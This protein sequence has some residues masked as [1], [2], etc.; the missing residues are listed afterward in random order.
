MTG[1]K[2][3]SC[4]KIVDILIPIRVLC[5]TRNGMEM[6]LRHYCPHC[7]MDIVDDWDY[8]GKEKKP[9]K[10]DEEDVGW[11]I[12]WYFYDK[13]SKTYMMSYSVWNDE[14]LADKRFIQLDKMKSVKEVVKAKI[15]CIKNKSWERRK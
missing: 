12:A 11:I 10:K 3:D 2:C 6:Q 4:N 7:F 9:K 8:D 1:S 14:G 5:E 15:I 13:E